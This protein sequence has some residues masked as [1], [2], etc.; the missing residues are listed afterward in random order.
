MKLRIKP[1][2]RPGWGRVDLEEARSEEYVIGSLRLKPT[3]IGRFQK[4]CLVFP[5]QKDMKVG[6]EVEV[7]M[8]LRCRLCGTFRASLINGMCDN[9]YEEMMVGVPPLAAVLYGGRGG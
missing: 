4:P 7:E 3:K 9:C 1:G 8:I 2:P 6:D 5:L